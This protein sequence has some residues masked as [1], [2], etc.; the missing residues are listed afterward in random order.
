MSV[1]EPD[2]LSLNRYSEPHAACDR[3]SEDDRVI[4]GKETRDGAIGEHRV[5]RG[6]VMVLEESE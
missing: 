4:G 6:V 1:C 5:D 2:A 3:A